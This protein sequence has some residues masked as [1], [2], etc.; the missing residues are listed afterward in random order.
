MQMTGLD[1]EKDDANADHEQRAGDGGATHAAETGFV[2][3]TLGAEYISL[4]AGL[5]LHDATLVSPILS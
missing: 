1:Q 3:V 2:R 5:F 4:G